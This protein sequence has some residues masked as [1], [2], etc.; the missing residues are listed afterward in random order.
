[1]AATDNLKVF[2]IAARTN[3][4]GTAADDVDQE[5]LRLP[6]GAIHEPGYLP[7]TVD[8]RTNLDAFKVR[9]NT[10]SDMNLKVGSGTSKKDA[11]VLRGTVAGQGSYIVRLDATTKTVAVPAADATNPARYGVYLVVNDTAYSGTASRAYVD[12]VCIRGTPAGSPTTPGPLAVWSAYELL[13]EF[14]LAANATAVTNTILD[15][16]TAVDRRKASIVTP[17]LGRVLVRK[18]AAQ[19]A[20]N[21][22]PTL[23]SWDTEDLDRDGFISVPSATLT[24][25]AG[26]GGV[27]AV[28]AKTL[29]TAGPDPS[30]LEIDFEVNSTIYS[31]WSGLFVPGQWQIASAVLALPAATNFN[32]LVTQQTGG[33]L[34]FTASLD[35]YRLSN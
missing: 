27:Y 33:A 10:G 34:N 14:Q 24:V 29:W 25:P 19:S 9:Q 20:T 22:S 30:Q 31:A 32:V 3:V 17:T 11:Y 7:S 28:I 16:G 12:V 6:T 21:N 26:L 18:V 2:A 8:Q 1:M 23:I 13:W 15:S 5:E 35:M 4:A